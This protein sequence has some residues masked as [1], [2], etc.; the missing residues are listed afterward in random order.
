ME[1]YRYGRDEVESVNF[2]E[3]FREGKP[4]CSHT[5]HPVRERAFHD[6][7]IRFRRGIANTASGARL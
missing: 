2:A 1:V 5:T 4:E 6:T 3:A 7:A